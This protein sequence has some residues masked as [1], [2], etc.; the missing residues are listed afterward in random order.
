[1]ADLSCTFHVLL[2]DIGGG[3]C[4]KHE[5]RPGAQLPVNLS[6]VE[7]VRARRLQVTPDVMSN[8]TL[9]DKQTQGNFERESNS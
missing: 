2:S 4:D 3:V 9:F 6:E 5:G 7:V 1:M 8:S